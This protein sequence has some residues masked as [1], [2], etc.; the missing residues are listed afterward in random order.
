[1]GACNP[2]ANGHV[3]R[4]HGNQVPKLD[5]RLTGAGNID[6]EI[7]M[8]LD[9]LLRDCKDESCMGHPLHRGLG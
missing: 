8:F 3:L 4:R 1:M 5:Q 2:M 9:L 6:D 7:Q